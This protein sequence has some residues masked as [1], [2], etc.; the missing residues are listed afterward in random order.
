MKYRLR[1][2]PATSEVIIDQATASS[3]QGITVSDPAP[4]ITPVL[5]PLPAIF[6]GKAPVNK[7]NEATREAVVKAILEQGMTITS[8]AEK[9]SIHRDTASAILQE[10]RR[11]TGEIENLRLGNKFHKLADKVVDELNKK[12][13]S[14][15][16]PSQLGILAGIAVDKK[17][18]LTG[19]PATGAGNISLRIAW[20]D[21]SGAAELN[22][23]GGG[24]QD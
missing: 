24:G 7:T 12:D 6:E 18:L 10:Y 20:K 2:P 3:D 14:A 16:S 15:A 4:S 9:F 1:K 5:D 17:I 8:V 21:G 11:E 19:K 22:V 13:L 23:G